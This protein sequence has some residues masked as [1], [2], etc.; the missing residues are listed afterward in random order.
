MGMVLIVAPD[1]ELRQSLQFALE[2]D[3]HQVEACGTLME[4]N[5]KDIRIDCSILD[6]HAADNRTGDVAQ[7]YAK[8]APVVLLANVSTHPLVERSFSTVLKPLLGLPL[9][10]AV[11]RALGAAQ[12]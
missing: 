1:A 2:A 5:Q 9:S 11:T 7:F 4:A 6:H 3:G 8:F 10:L 12:I